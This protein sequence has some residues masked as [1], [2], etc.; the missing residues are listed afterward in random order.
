MQDAR[1][2]TLRNVMT[3]SGK[4]FIKTDKETNLSTPPQMWC[5]VFMTL[6]VS[7]PSNRPHTVFQPEPGAL[8]GGGSLSAL[9]QG[10]QQRRDRARTQCWELQ[11]LRT[12]RPTTRKDSRGLGEELVETAGRGG[13]GV[14]TQS[15]N[16]SPG[17]R[18][19]GERLRRRA[20]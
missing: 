5:C 8:E 13:F 2:E 19:V 9:E 1:N 11:K 6:A 4:N 14:G 20:A 12:N 10:E 3:Q 18:Q 16:S 15:G 17:R 7:C